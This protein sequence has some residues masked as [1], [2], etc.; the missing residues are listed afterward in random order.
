MI[1]N[2]LNYNK[3]TGEDQVNYFFI[4]IMAVVANNRSLKF[5]LMNILH[6][7]NVKDH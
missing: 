3:T 7:N 1:K 2:I 5:Q 4:Q 6:Q